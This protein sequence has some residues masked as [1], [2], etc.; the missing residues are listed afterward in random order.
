MDSLPSLDG[1][2]YVLRLLP[3]FYLSIFDVG[4]FCSP[5]V[6]GLGTPS[7]ESLL[8]IMPVVDVDMVQA[9][10]DPEP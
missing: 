8:P 6:T 2:L 4:R 1:I 10:E 5:Y 7:F 3:D 9:R